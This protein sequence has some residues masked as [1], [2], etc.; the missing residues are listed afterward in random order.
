MATIRGERMKLLGLDPDDPASGKVLAE[1]GARLYGAPVLAV[2]CMDKALT[3]NLDLGLLVQTICLAALVYGVDTLIAG[4]S[5]AHPDVLRKVLGIPEELH[6]V[7][8]VL[9]GHANPNSPL[10]SYRSPRRPVEEVVR[11]KE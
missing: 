7:T 2:I 1:M 5:V 8:G 3:N 6:I 4:T 11:Y 9:L 10:N